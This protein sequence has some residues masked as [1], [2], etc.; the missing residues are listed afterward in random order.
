[1]AFGDLVE[2]AGSLE[3]A[4]LLLMREHPKFPD[5]RERHVA[6]ARDRGLAVADVTSEPSAEPWLAACDIVT[7]SL[8]L[9]GLDHAYLSAY[10]PRAIGVA[11]YLMTNA[12]IRDYAQ[13]SCGIPC[14]PMADQGLGLVATG[15]EQLVAQLERSL[16]LDE[17]K[18][19]FK[20]S[21]RLGKTDPCEAIVSAVT[22]AVLEPSTEA[23]GARTPA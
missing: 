12:E 19:Y 23:L 1:M 9:C 10:S 16:S 8:S 18:A 3:P 21:K 5:A 13:R 7:T 11:V 22:S 20:A 17:R 14:L 15:P 2:A 4:P 6:L